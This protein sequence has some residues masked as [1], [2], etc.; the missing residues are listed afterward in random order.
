MLYLNP[1]PG[2]DRDNHRRLLEELQYLSTDL[3]DTTCNYA[4]S[5]DPLLPD[6]DNLSNDYISM[7]NPASTLSTL[8]FDSDTFTTSSTIPPSTIPDSISAAYNY[9][10]AST[11]QVTHTGEPVETDMLSASSF[12]HDSWR[13]LD[14]NAT[15]KS[16][17]SL[18]QQQQSHATVAAAA[19]TANLI[20]RRSSLHS[21][22]DGVP[23]RP[24]STLVAKS[25]PVSKSPLHNF[26]HVS[27]TGSSLS[28]VS[29]TAARH[30]HLRD[31]GHTIDRTGFHDDSD[32]DN[33]NEG[34][35]NRTGHYNNI[36]NNKFSHELDNEISRDDD[37]DDVDG[38]DSDDDDSNDAVLEDDNQED[39]D[40]VQEEDKDDRDTHASP[41]TVLDDECNLYS[42]RSIA[43]TPPLQK[44]QDKVA[45]AVRP[46]VS[47]FSS[48]KS[49]H[50][51]KSTP[52]IV[53][54]TSPSAT[55]TT[56]STCM[57]KLDAVSSMNVPTTPIS[58]TLSEK[59]NSKAVGT[60]HDQE[61]TMDTQSTHQTPV[62]LH[63]HQFLGRKSSTFTS[64]STAHRVTILHPSSVPA[65][66]TNALANAKDAET[67]RKR[68]A[69][70]MERFRRKKAVR[71][72]GRRVRYQIRKRI[73]TTRPRVNGRFAKRSDV[74]HTQIRPSSPHC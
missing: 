1:S 60:S 42:P 58:P 17:S 56:T 73:A 32:I 5:C 43:V 44:H 2:S 38:D 49:P 25:C 4:P 11:M 27:K 69:E 21:S 45:S 28:P 36:S 24:R 54:V 26:S 68:R 19:V 9:A 70:A 14:T 15:D 39:D 53:G 10:T 61:D 59:S 55:T 63:H 46:F 31:V 71:C 30:G 3:E 40:D 23:K 57:M 72:Y 41:L 7:S 13:C 67:C 74:E 51:M 12:F 6:P 29:V 37:D 52:E 50:Q 62:L 16:S 66:I 33:D 8:D 34:D 65:A 20:L 18:H 64:S 22:D 48:V 47:N 35:N